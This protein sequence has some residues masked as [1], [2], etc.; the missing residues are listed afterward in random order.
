MGY[1]DLFEQISDWRNTKSNRGNVVVMNRIHTDNRFSAIQEVSAYWEAL[2]GDRIMPKR[3]EIDP[4]GI[5]HALE[6][7]FV[8]ERIAPGLAR[9]R[10]AGSHL[11]DLMGMEVRGMPVTSFFTPA[12]RKTLSDILEDVFE[13]PA[14]VD[15]TLT[16]ERGIGKPPLE[17]R[18]LLLPMTSDLGDVSRILGCLVAKGEIGR[19]PRRFEISGSTMRVLTKAPEQFT[20]PAQPT[21]AAEPVRGFAETKCA[22]DRTAPHP[23]PK[24]PFL[25]L[26][27]NNT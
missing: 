22:L 20:A 17:A 15:L 13:R 3:S 4:R 1:N 26:V 6:N 10:V 11:N 21:K 12:G 25:K 2:R 7:A 18:M 9:M 14:V 19:Q 16:A 8:L 27:C 23:Q 24:A 5:E